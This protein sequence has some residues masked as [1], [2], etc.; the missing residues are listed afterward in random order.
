M[1]RTPFI[2]S[3]MIN[4]WN[5][6][7][8]STIPLCFI[9]LYLFHLFFIALF[10]RWFYRFSDKRGPKQGLF[11][12]NLHES[13]KKL[14]YYHF[15]S[16]LLKYPIFAFIRS[17]FP[18]LINWELRFIGSNKIGKNTVIEESFLHSHIDMGKNTYLG[19]FTHITNHLVDG[20]Y[21][22]ENLTFFGSQLGDGVVFN[23]VSGGF[24]G[25]EMGSN[26]TY[27]S[28]GSTIKYDELGKNNVYSDF[29]ARKLTKEEINERLGGLYDGED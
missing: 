20:I 6:L 1:S 9:L 22:Q 28:V 25:L 10:T 3:N 21:G 12:R 4:I 7:I 26:S 2:F 5:V 8:L 24:P 16:F 13:S 15:R 11:D 18:W 19:T 27:L 14:E 29:P 23:S 17:P